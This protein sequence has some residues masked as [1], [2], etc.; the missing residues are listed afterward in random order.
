M[1]LAEQLHWKVES[2]YSYSST[3]VNVVD[4]LAQRIISWGDENIADEDIYTG[5]E[6]MGREDTPHITVLYGIVSNEPDEAITLLEDKEIGPVKATLGKVSLFENS[7]DYDVVKI[8]VDS[9][10]L[11]R[12]NKL[13]FDNLE[14]ESS[15]PEYKP[16]VTIAYVNK[17]SGK[18]YSGSDEFEG[19]ELFFD[20]IRF[21]SA[22]EERTMIDLER[23]VVAELNWSV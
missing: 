8:E 17:G 12:I 1:N 20:E 19:T 22:D 23:N 18:L 21:S 10:D 16:H 6:N 14:N 2:D 4:D 5:E 13:F 7:D 11:S 15:F 3:Q 9:E